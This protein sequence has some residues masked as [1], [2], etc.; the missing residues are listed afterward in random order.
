MSTTVEALS[1]DLYPI[2]RTS[3]KTYY[4]TERKEPVLPQMA[5]HHRKSVP[6]RS[7]ADAAIPKRFKQYR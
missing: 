3:I 7:R 2:S 1:I 4:P 5:V 6:V